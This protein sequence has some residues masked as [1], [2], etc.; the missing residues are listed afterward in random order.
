MVINGENV[1]DKKKIAEAFNKYFADIGQQE[2][3]NL[4]TT[5]FAPIGTF[6][7]EECG[8]QR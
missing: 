3:N 4:H 7:E 5:R 6:P 1:T 2:A 8:A